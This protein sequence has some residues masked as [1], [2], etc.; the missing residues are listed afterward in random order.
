MIIKIRVP[1]EMY[2]EQCNYELSELLKDHTF[3]LNYK[4]NQLHALEHS[5]KI[6]CA[7]NFL[8]N[9]IDKAAKQI[10]VIIIICKNENKYI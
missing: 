3:C 6:Q 10:Q 4:E 1:S 7:L 5:A 9:F 8:N 2:S